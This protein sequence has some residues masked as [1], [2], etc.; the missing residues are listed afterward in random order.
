M[1]LMLQGIQDTV[2]SY[3]EVVAKIT[4]VDAEVVDA[5]LVRI[6]GTGRYAT[7]VG[8]SIRGESAVY[9]HVM[10]IRRS[11]VLDT[12]REHHICQR[13]D[14]REFCQETFSLSTP[15]LEGREVHGVI[16][17]VCFTDEDR[18]RFMAQRET[19]TA[20]IE[21]CAEF[22]V[23][24]LRDRQDLRRANAFLD[25]MLR[26]LDI[27]TRGILIFNARGGISYLNDVARRELAELGLEL[28][29]QNPL[30]TDIAVRRT[31]E[32]FGDHDEFVLRG[33]ERSITLMGR[34]E[35][36]SNEP[37]FARVFTFESIPRLADRAGSAF[38]GSESG[39]ENL[40]G[41]SPAMERIKDQIRQ[42]AGSTSTVLISG[43]SGTGK[44]MVARAIHSVSERRD[45]PF[46]GVNCG[47][48]PDALLESELFGYAGGAFT[49]ASSKGRIG[50]FELAHKGVLFLDEITTLP[51]YLQVK[52]LRALQE[53]TFTR[54]GSNRLIEVDIRIIAACNENLRDCVAQGRFREDLYYRLN[55]IPLDIPPL[56]ERVDDIPLLAEYFL[57]KYARLFGKKPPRPDRAL[58][59]ALTTYPWPGNV[60]EFENTMEFM[61]NMLNDERDLGVDLLPPHV[62][63]ASPARSPQ[64]ECAPAEAAPVRAVRPLAE[65]EREAIEG[66][67]TLF[68]S[69][70]GGKRAAAAALGIGVA[71]L[72]RKLKDYG[73]E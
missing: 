42:I 40:L 43:E 1:R 27:N 73:S 17:L 32:R 37:H 70:T 51:L 28:D 69:D 59:G 60:R 21:Q 45:K 54:L 3:A 72:Y 68:G 66:A 58:L 20:F 62:R 15:I 18:L 53:R 7:G 16:G 11:F 55:V 29:P 39:L 49:G 34:M 4:G 61:I 5:G 6:A 25:V 63:K 38:A 24:K 52:L 14:G 9:R 65:V 2:A 41:H 50:K 33:R 56:R 67:L 35:D 57:E 44:E 22:I 8:Q 64:A 19:Y 31:G 12:P 47:A 10:R 13:C 26:I 71:T 46:V 36:L 48:I 30:P 23:H